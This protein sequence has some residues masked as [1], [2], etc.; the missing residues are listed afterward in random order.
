[1]RRSLR[2]KI[3]RGAHEI[4]GTCVELESKGQRIVLDVGRPINAARNEHIPL[5]QVPGMVKATPDLLGVL[6]S[7][8]HQDHWGL[9]GQVDPAVPIFMGEATSRI[10]GEADF[11]TSGLSRPVAGNLSDRHTLELGPFTITPYLND[12]SAFDAYSL[13]IE[14][15]G[16]RLFYTGDIRGHGRKQGLFERLVHRPPHDVNVLLMEGTNIR[17]TAGDDAGAGVTE[18]DVEVAMRATMRSTEGLVLV[19]SSAQNIDRLVTTYRAALEAGRVLVMDLYGASI[20]RATG[21]ANIP[22]PG[23]AWPKVHVYVPQWQRVRVKT[24]GAFDRV[25]A[26]KPFRVFEKYLAEHRSDVVMMFSMASASAL[27]K[28]G[29]LTDATLIWSL[30][31]GY[32]LEES[33]RRLQGFLGEHG[34][35]MVEHHTSGHASVPDLKRLASAMAPDRLVPIHSFG[36]ARFA[37]LFDNVVAEEDGVWWEV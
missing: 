2:A 22:Q 10:L 16:R 35:P 26:V 20:A 6:I 28:A 19:Y 9:V 33:G 37:D 36:G 25:E 34:I 13:L 23:E 5:P 17:P 14:A 11:W 29:A 8:A 30:W 18:G 32:L 24:A 12:H 1:M 3:H 21:N 7:H 4:G 27:D 31:H 15:D